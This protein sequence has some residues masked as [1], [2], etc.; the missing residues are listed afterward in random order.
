MQ[1][2]TSLDDIRL[3]NSW[4]T[5]GSFDGVHLG[6]QQIVRRL[7]QGAHAE[8]LPAAVLT[9]FPPPAVVLQ[10][11]SD[12]VYLTLPPERARLFGELGVDIV[13]T[14]PFSLELANTS[15]TEFTRQVHAQL[16]FSHLC[17]GYDFALGRGREGNVDFLRALGVQIGY[18]LAIQEPV[19]NDGHVISSSQIRRALA[20]GDAALAGRLL[21]RPYRMTGEVVHGDGRGHTIGIPTANL[22]LPAERVVPRSGVYACLAHVDG[23]PWPAVTNIGVRPTFDNQPVLPQVETHLLDYRQDL[24]GKVIDLDFVDRLRDEQRFPSVTALVEQIQRDI[25]KARTVLPILSR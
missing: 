8:Q 17:V 21:G 10:K 19:Q 15:A 9:F 5:I 24:Y 3:A 22:T 1:H 4:L 11:R 12:A 13:I 2:F 25:D 6:H 16:N 23:T 14:Q 18:T 20:E 7:V